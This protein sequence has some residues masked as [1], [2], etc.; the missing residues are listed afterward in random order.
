MVASRV[1][2]KCMKSSVIK[3]AAALHSHFFPEKL[4]AEEVLHRNKR[5][6]VSVPM[7][8]ASRRASSQNIRIPRERISFPSGGWVVS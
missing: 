6:P 7:N 5:T 3:I 2:A 4:P 8:T 1:W